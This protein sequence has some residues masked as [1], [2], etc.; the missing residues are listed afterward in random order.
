MKSNHH[1]LKIICDN[2]T[3][4]VYGEIIQSLDS[5]L[6][7]LASD[8]NDKALHLIVVVIIS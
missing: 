7:I 3:A 5:S 6:F 8:K 1:A 2:L 4:Y